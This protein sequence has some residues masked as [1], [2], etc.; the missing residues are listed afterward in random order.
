MSCT[1]LNKRIAFELFLRY[2]LHE[3]YWEL[4]YASI[5]RKRLAAFSGELFIA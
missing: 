3:H 4:A 1:V 2:E 5:L